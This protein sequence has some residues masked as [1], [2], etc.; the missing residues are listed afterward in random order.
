MVGKLCH[1]LLLFSLLVFCEA[2]DVVKFEVF[3]ELEPGTFVGDISTSSIV[4]KLKTFDGLLRFQFLGFVPR[5]SFGIN[6]TTGVIRTQGKLDR[7]KLS[8]F[9][10]TFQI[11]VKVSIGLVTANIPIE[12]KVRDINDNSPT[13]REKVENISVSESAPLGAELAV[14]VAEDKDIG[15]NT[16]QSYEVISRNDGGIF[17]L[18]VSRPTSELTKVKLVVSKRL[19]RE[20]NDSFYLVLEARDG[21]NP[22][23][24]ARKGLNITVLDSNDHIPKFSKDL[25][26]G[27]VRENSQ[28]GTFVLKV[29][30][31]DGDVGTNAEIVFSLKPRPQYENLFVLDAQ[32]GELRTNA[33]LDYERSNDYQLEV[34]AKDKGPDSIPSSA[35][36]KVKVLDENDNIP[37]ITVTS[38]QDAFDQQGRIPE[39]SPVQ[40]GVAIVTVRDSDSG[41]NGRVTVTLQHHKQDF[42]LQEMFAGQYILEVRRPLSLDRHALYKIKI[43]AEDQGLP[44]TLQNSHVFEV[45]LADSNR[46]APVFS[47]KVYNLEIRDDIRIGD[48]IT[49]VTAVDKDDGRNA[50]LTYILE[51]IRIGARNG[52]EEDKSK[53]FKIDSVTGHV[54]VLSKLWCP[55][56]PSFVLNIDV[57]DDGR[58]PFHG[59]TTL[60]ISIRCSKHVYNFSVAENKRVGTVV[61]RIPFSSVAPD[62]P[63]HI[64]L[65]SDADQEFA[66]DNKTGILTTKSMLDR[67]DINTYSLI[68]VLSDG[69]VEKQLTVNI[70]VED[71]NDNAPVFVDLHSP[72]NMTLTNGVFIG[73]TVLKVDAVDKD[74]GS[75]GLVEY[76]IIS[77]NEG[78]V[79]QINKNNGRISLKKQLNKTSYHLT[80][81][82]SDSGV[83]REQ[84]FLRLSISVK[85]I[86]P[87]PPPSGFPGKKTQRPGTTSVDGGV[88][89]NR[90]GDGGFFADTTMIIIVAVSAG[91]LLLTICL[92]AIFC[93]WFR[94]RS[95]GKKEEE[96][97]HRGSYHEPDISRE[98]AL[99]ASKK[100]FHQA[101]A[102]QRQ[103][104]EVCFTYGTRQK[105]INVSPIPIKKMHPMT[106]QPVGTGSPT[107]TVRPDMYYPV[108]QEVPEECHSSE[109]ELD[110]GRGGSSRSSPYCAHSPPSKKK[111]DHWSHPHVRYNAPAPYGPRSPS[112]PPPPPPYE[113]VQRRKAFVTISG[114]THSTTD[115]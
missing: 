27:E 103:S 98:D 20:K 22:P 50:E 16:V 10:D 70:K 81:R 11:Q 96:V 59:K 13:F 5:M 88:V 82:A 84:S 38:L 105:P 36:I 23:R 53:W 90:K 69:S 63:L 79:F 18:K 113:E 67:E 7:E 2:A 43:V 45:K 115:L 62:R 101:T 71:V 64:R 48:V 95:R 85:F 108:E 17:D 51:G 42:G 72:H 102:N 9:A 49:R 37:Q 104:H 44:T 41:R 78:Q 76:A 40:T 100:M 86:T 61:G 83:I 21:G 66:L 32:T 34:T 3:E 6:S 28:P 109:D 89:D 65:L 111:E 25:Y 77:G 73:E 97:D 1:R 26:V 112:M 15:N 99:K 87:A 4:E 8:L 31:T 68:A 106:H 91:V 57:R 47:Q 30:A 46:H 110:S 92:T 54:L 94:R 114:V 74:S 80:I 12:I 75:N 93:V 52:T 39:D 60:N 29:N 33:A 35:V 24:V 107:A 14:T 55:F 19:D 58:V 56:T